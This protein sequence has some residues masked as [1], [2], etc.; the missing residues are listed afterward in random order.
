MNVSMIAGIRGVN[1][2][3]SAIS[4]GGARRLSG[5]FFIHKYP[6]LMN[7]AANHSVPIEINFSSDRFK[8]YTKEVES[9]IGNPVRL[10]LDNHVP[11]VIC[12]FRGMTSSWDRNETL[13][14]TI[15]QCKL[16]AAMTMNLLS[17]GFR[18]NYQSYAFRQKIYSDFKK[19]A[20]EIFTSHGFKFMY[21]YFYFPKEK[22]KKDI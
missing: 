21:N 16:S 13:Y 20:E 4:E 12:S 22:D 6:R 1:S 2:L 17:T 7:Y 11:V 18:F 5:A 14:Q 15:T 10:L 3:I 9:F 19:K 8:D